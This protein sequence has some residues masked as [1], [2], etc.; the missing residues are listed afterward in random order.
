MAAEGTGKAKKRAVVAVA[1]KLAGVSAHAL[2][3]PG[4]L[5]L[6][7]ARRWAAPIAT[8]FRNSPH[9]TKTSQ[10]RRPAAPQ[11][12]AGVS[13][14]EAL[15]AFRDPCWRLS[16]FYS[17]RTCDGAV[18]KFSPHPQ[19]REIIDLIYRQA[20]RL[21]SSKSRQI[22]SS[23]LLGVICAEW[24][25]FGSVQHTSLIDHTIEDARQSC[26]TLRWW[27]TTVSIRRSEGKLPITCSN[28]GQLAVKFIRY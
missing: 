3:A 20:Y 26:G 28:T 22:G 17:I 13:E 1:R 6:L 27:P 8:V 16:R 14:E 15:E 23:T 5:S 11:M 18:I 24:L 21:S 2:E 4:T 10:A 7:V 19:Q 25:R 9:R 12:L